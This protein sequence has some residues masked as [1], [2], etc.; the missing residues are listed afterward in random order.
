VLNALA[1]STADHRSRRHDDE[2]D[3]HFGADSIGGDVD[4][5]MMNSILP[6]FSDESHLR[7]QNRLRLF[8]KRPTQI[9]TVEDQA[10]PLHI[11]NPPVPFLSWSIADELIKIGANDGDEVVWFSTT[12]AYR[13]EAAAIKLFSDRNASFDHPSSA[14]LFGDDLKILL[15]SKF[16]M[17]TGMTIEQF[18]KKFS[19]RVLFVKLFAAVEVRNVT[20]RRIIGWPRGMNEA[21][22]KVIKELKNH[23]H[24][25]VMFASASEVRNRGVK[26]R[27]P[28][29]TLHP[30]G[31]SSRWRRCELERSSRHPSRIHATASRRVLR[32]RRQHRGRVAILLSKKEVK[33]R[34]L[35]QVG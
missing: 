7:G 9:A 4:D 3:E 27:H 25:R 18:K 22:R 5:A 1:K 12:P 16:A 11:Q 13:D 34:S 17:N 20:R 10:F 2:R 8:A 35:H 26:F 32:Q 21:E 24:A 33:H 28:S 30:L 29:S 14:A 19:S 23:R 6:R 31:Q 15:D